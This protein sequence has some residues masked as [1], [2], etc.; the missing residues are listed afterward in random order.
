MGLLDL[1]VGQL[2]CQLSKSV[3]FIYFAF[4][5]PKGERFKKPVRVG[6]RCTNPSYKRFKKTNYSINMIF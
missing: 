2:S 6:L 5:D 1:M 3:W 4:C